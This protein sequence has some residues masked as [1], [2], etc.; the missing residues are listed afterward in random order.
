M[1]KINK[2]F[3]FFFLIT[4]FIGCQEDFLEEV[5]FVIEAPANVTANFVITQD[6]T[7]L[8][9]IT[10]QAEGAT[11]FVINSFGDGSSDAANDIMPGTSVS[12]TYTEGT[13]DVSLTA[14][15]LNGL[16]TSAT[17]PLT[18]SFRA[19][20]NLTLILAPEALTLTVSAKA[21][22]ATY[23]HV[24]FGIE[25]EDPVEL[26][27]DGSVNYTYPT[28]GDYDVKVIAFSG[29]SATT[30]KT[31]T[32]TMF[33]ETLLPVDFESFDTN[34]FISFGGTSNS[35][36]DNPDSSGNS[37]AKVGK[38]VKGAGETWAGNVITTTNPIKDLSIKNQIKVKVWSPRAGGTMTMKLENIDDAAV[39]SGEISATLSG[40]KG[41][42][43]V[44]FDMSAIDSSKEYRKIV[45][46]FD[47]GT[48][49]EGGDDWTFYVDDFSQDAKVTEPLTAAPKPLAH[50][51]NV[52]SIFSN[53]YT[54]VN[55]SEW[56]PNWG[57]STTL[58]T[59]KI[60]GNE[61]LLYQNLN[62]SGL[63]TNYDPG[64]AL[65]G[66]TYVHFD[67]WTVDATKLGLKLVNT[68]YGDG[69]PKKEAL[70][71]VDAITKG[72]WVS[73]DIPLSD[74]TNDTAKFMQLV[75]DG[76]ASKI[77]IDNLYF[78]NLPSDA[79]AAAA[80][81]PSVASDDVISIYSD[82]YTN[83]NVSEWNPDWGQSTTL[84]TVTI[85]GNNILKYSN[86]NYSGLVTNYDP[87]TD[88]SSM[89]YVHFDYWTKDATK[90]GLKL[91]NTAHANNDEGK[92]EALVFAPAIV[93]GGWV[94][95]DIPLSDY[96]NDTAKFMQLVWDGNGTVYIDNL[97]F[98]ENKPT[99]APA[100]P[101]AA[102][103]DV[104]SIFSDSYTNENVSEWNPDWGQSTT[105]ET[106]TIDGNS[107]LKYSNLNYSGLV[108]NY[109]PGT[110]IS[111]KTHVHFDYWTP[112]SS[113]LGLK[114]VNTAHADNDEGKKEALVLV[115]SVN[116]GGWVSVD[117][118]LSDYTNDTAK[119]MQLVWDG[120]GTVYID[121][122]YFVKK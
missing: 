75:W 43:E 76:S 111:T 92:K 80:A 93:K 109:D 50:P 94:S 27:V 32:V 98:Y 116:K 72:E 59:V 1:K 4:A 82:S 20:E 26:A 68:A 73:V 90:L 37:S 64:T 108:T 119:F 102:A 81:A 77:W 86:L 28:G 69:D 15:G 24:Y 88:I 95:V 22:F 39:N 100:A 83:E 29:G 45:W 105:L 118:P 12:H 58:E 122:L 70:V 10:P 66:K 2:I 106:V 5:D 110:D 71:S 113:K 21:D 23:F 67:Y 40:N 9:T 25:G 54:N 97:Y 74:Y 121:N 38:V 99:V 48:M 60:E 62:Y 7:G 17:V 31:E 34:V 84:E 13:F 96:T 65:T 19:P 78:Y 47:L 41:W 61:T 112:N 115:S 89:N 114:L 57:Q 101:S 35:V 55:V 120:N 16:K 33:T 3:T 30:E 49:G 87:G 103:S 53:Q 51:D 14:N 63:V 11:S 18:V 107:I 46:F 56:N 117:I 44:I 104:T 85:D 36:I 79:P 6:N 91:V 52:V 42:E 8:V